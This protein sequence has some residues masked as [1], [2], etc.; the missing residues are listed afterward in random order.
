MFL[1]VGTRGVRG[2]RDMLILVT[3]DVVGIGRAEE[4]TG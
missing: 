3:E 2:E 4:K 1:S